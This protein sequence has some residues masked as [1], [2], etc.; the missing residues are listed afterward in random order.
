MKLDAPALAPG[1]PPKAAASAS[2][3]G[4]A[5]E[6]TSRGGI[7]L[8]L[9][10]RALRHERFAHAAS[11]V[12]SEL[13]LL[14]G[15]ERVSIGFHS[16]SK[17]RVAAMSG[18]SDV[19]MR[20]NLVRAVA[21]AME[22]CLD[23]RSTVIHPL[24]RGSS[25]A[26]ALAHAE[27]AV[28][29]GQLAICTVPIIGRSRT[30]GAIVFE[31]REGFDVRALELAKDAALFV[32]P[33][34][35]LK[36]RL[37]AP[38]SGRIAEA[39]APRGRRLAGTTWLT[40]GRLAGAVA[41]AAAAVVLAWPTTYRVVATAR[42]EGAVQ[43]VMAAPS[44]GFLREVHVR[45]GDAV[46]SGQLLAALDDRELALERDKWSAEI[47]QLDK[48]YR[49]ALSRDDAAQIVIARSK[50]EQ[51]QAQLDLALKQL[52]RSQLK[53]PIDGVVIAGDLSQA[54]GTPVKRGQELMTLAPDRRF[55]VVAEVDEQDVAAMREGQRANVM[56]AALTERPL[57]FVVTRISP[58]ATTIDARNV[59]EVEGRVDDREAAGHGTLRHGLRGVARI[60]IDE[61]SQGLIWWQRLADWARR[62]AWRLLG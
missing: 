37:D 26:V 53:A 43:R 62:L 58:V 24:P 45:P 11:A 49:E 28:A 19:R 29:N 34:L 55:R 57:P 59:F 56:F 32:G 38:V 3:G 15:C 41:A 47:A 1:K 20:Q 4:E 51:S 10:A 52:E 14:L 60:D 40:S 25:A 2:A 5:R 31:R 48:Q 12:V 35:E 9:Q 61:R 17:I 54:I 42:V 33:I 13:A 36:H 46:R 50:L 22:E 18:P 8:A 44:D 21:A 23:Q 7:V 16:Q 6:R 27:L 30:L 39:V